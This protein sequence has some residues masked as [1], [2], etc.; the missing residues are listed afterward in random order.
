MHQAR[1]MGFC[2]G[3]TTVRATAVATGI[4]TAVTVVVTAK[5]AYRETPEQPARTSTKAYKPACESS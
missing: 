2:T 1:C 4:T 5:Y 3:I